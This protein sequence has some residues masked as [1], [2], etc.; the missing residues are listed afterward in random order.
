[1][2]WGTLEKATEYCEQGKIEEWIQSFLR[3]DGHNVV[4]ANGLLLENRKYIGIIDFD[5]EM[6]ND[7]KKGAPEYLS[8]EDDIK[9]FFDLVTKMK[10]NL[11][12]WNPPPLII[13]Y[14]DDGLF[15]VCDGRHRLEL[16]RQIGKKRVPAIVWTTGEKNYES[17]KGAIR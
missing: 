14:R 15:Y 4:L 7:V 17:L 1:M 11:Q 9:Y 13:E 3:N 8:K 16:Y 12:N 5:I 2:I 10:S 6:L